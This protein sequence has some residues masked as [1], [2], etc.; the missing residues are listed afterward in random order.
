MADTLLAGVGRVPITPPIGIDLVGYAVRE[1]GATAVHRE[2]YATALVFAAGAVRTVVVDCD[3]L[4]LRSP[5]VDR[6]R[7]RVA[8][9]VGTTVPHVLIACT[10]THSAP[11]T[12]VEL[13][14]GGGRQGEPQLSE[15]EAA[16]MTNLGYLIEGAAAMAAAALRPARI[17]AGEGRATFNINRREKLPGGRVVIGRNPEGACDHSVGVLRIDAT[18]GT[19]LAGIINYACH[20][21][22]L[23]P[24]SYRISPDFPG[25]AKAVAEANVGAP[26][27]YLMG[28]C[29]NIQ[30][31]ETTAPDVAPAEKL[32]A[33]LGA[34]AARVFLGLRTQRTVTRRTLIES[35]APLSTYT[36]EP[37][38]DAPPVL[39]AAEQRLE[40]PLCP[41]PDEAGAALLAGEKRAALDQLRAAGAPRGQ[42]NVALIQDEWAQQVLALARSGVRQASVPTMLQ[43]LRIGDVA[44]AAVG[45]EAFVEIGLQVKADSPLPATLFAGYSNG[46]I[47][48]I[49]TPES[50][51]DGGYEVENSHKNFRLP[52]AVAPAGCAMVVDG[53]LRLLRQVA[54]QT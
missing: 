39:A 9:R 23:G 1:H 35:M 30:P 38:P 19:P 7:E 17:A 33:V 49:P 27:L 28:A 14:I 53:L 10:H 42:L 11:V 24:Q 16:Y 29:G 21:I 45:A 20:P 26:C 31:L 44:I 15:L 18:D 36:E 2:L 13:R 12:A 43:A 41:L 37:L 32:G 4:A 6:L 48:Y 46:C 52:T 50:Y 8:A 54:D 51:P 25:V 5:Y 47:G 3:L 40:L 22:T 34:E